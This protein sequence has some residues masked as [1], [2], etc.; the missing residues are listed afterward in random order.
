ME[1]HYA[2]AV[3]SERINTI[4]GLIPDDFPSRDA[5]TRA[6]RGRQGSLNFTAPTAVP[7]RW[8]EVAKILEKS[9]PAD[10]QPWVDEVARVFSADY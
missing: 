3:L 5:V 6:L 4:I 2:A 8:H 7:G 10:G 1:E 9:L